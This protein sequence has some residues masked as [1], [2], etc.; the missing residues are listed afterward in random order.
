M[1]LEAIYHWDRI[2]ASGLWLK[3]QASCGQKDPR[4]PFLRRAWRSLDV[5][6]PDK[7][8]QAGVGAKT[9]S[10]EATIVLSEK[11]ML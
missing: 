9:R 10:A 4:K 1:Q 6:P 8:R 3:V 2:V 11:D 5:S 7:V